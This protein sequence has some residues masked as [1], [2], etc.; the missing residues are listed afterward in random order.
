MNKASEALE[1]LA[2]LEVLEVLAAADEDS[3]PP[4]GRDKRDPP[5]LRRMR[6]AAIPPVA[7]SATLPLVRLPISVF[8]A[9]SRSALLYSTNKYGTI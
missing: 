7:T 5:V 2:V 3:R 6:T 4:A 8:Y 9:N 1:V